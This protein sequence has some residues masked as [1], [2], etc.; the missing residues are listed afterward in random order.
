MIHLT[1]D[2]WRL[3]W[4]Q[5]FPQLTSH[6]CNRPAAPTQEAHAAVYRK[7]HDSPHKHM[8]VYSAPGPNHA[9]TPAVRRPGCTA[10]TARIC[11]SSN[12]ACMG[13]C[14]DYKEYFFFYSQTLCLTLVLFARLFGRLSC[15]MINSNGPPDRSWKCCRTKRTVAELEGP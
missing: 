9:C 2:A 15:V 4:L 14:S 11:V 5:S 1:V 6:T 12:F 13:G 7:R 10:R 8:D 3:Q